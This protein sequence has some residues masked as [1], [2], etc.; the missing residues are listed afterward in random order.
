MPRSTWETERRVKPDIWRGNESSR[1]DEERSSNSFH[2][3]R[4][5]QAVSLS[6]EILQDVS[7]STFDEDEQPGAFA[8]NRDGVDPLT[9]D[10]DQSESFGTRDSQS[11][12]LEDSTRDDIMPFFIQEKKDKSKM[13]KAFCCIKIERGF[14]R[15]VVLCLLT[16]LTVIV[17]VVGLITSSKLKAK[18]STKFHPFDKCDFS[19]ISL[20]TQIDP[21]LQ[22]ECNKNVEHILDIVTSAYGEIRNAANMTDVAIDIH[23]CSVENVALLWAATEYSMSGEITSNKRPMETIINRLGLAFMFLSWG[24]SYWTNKANW[25][26][27]DSECVWFGVTCDME[28][29]VVALGLSNNNLKGTIG[30]QLGFIRNLVNVDISINQ[31]HGT[32]HPSWWNLHNLGAL[33]CN[34]LM[35]TFINDL[36]INRCISFLEFVKER[37]FRYNST[38]AK[39]KWG[40]I[41]AFL[42]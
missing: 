1:T 36:T 40:S 8:I 32:I 19:T 24:G 10:W 15:L 26:K 27:P 31:M 33:R 2:V 20:T 29:R 37:N 21:I 25:M 14:T 17:I 34:M 30:T 3:E 18:N 5:S 4:R 7:S 23:S 42:G 22:C 9:L 13:E 39:R 41:I 12:P 6:G 38:T 35:N 28:K 16:S 11:K